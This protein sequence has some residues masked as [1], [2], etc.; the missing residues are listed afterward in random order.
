[1]EIMLT[2]LY[3][4]SGPISIKQRKYNSR[5]V[6]VMGC[7]LVERH[8]SLDVAGFENDFGQHMAAGMGHNV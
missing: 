8:W 2:L 5:Y 7:W 4:I 1:M 6:V 3:P